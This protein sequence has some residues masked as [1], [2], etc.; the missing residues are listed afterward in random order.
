MATTPE[1]L[2]ESRL[3]ISALQRDQQVLKSSANEEISL[4]QD[5]IRKE[6]KHTSGKDRIVDT[7]RGDIDPVE[8]ERQCEEKDKPERKI[9]LT[10]AEMELKETLD[11]N[12]K[13]VKII[14]ELQQE[15]LDSNKVG[16]HLQQKVTK[17]RAEMDKWRMEQ[18][19]SEEKFKKSKPTESIPEEE[20]QKVKQDF[21]DSK[22]KQN[23]LQSQIAQVKHQK[24]ELVS[25][26][27]KAMEAVTRTPEL[28]GKTL[29]EQA[30]EKEKKNPPSSVVDPLTN[31]TI[32]KL[33]EHIDILEE[34]LKIAQRENSILVEDNR[35]WTEDLMLANQMLLKA[36]KKLMREEKNT[37]LAS[38]T[39]EISA[40][41]K[42]VQNQ[43]VKDDAEVRWKA[44]HEGHAD[45]D[46]LTQEERLE[47][48]IEEY[49]KQIVPSLQKQIALKEEIIEKLSSDCLHEAEEEEELESELKKRQLENTELKTELE[50]TVRIDLKKTLLEDKLM[51][52]INNLKQL[53]LLKDQELAIVKDDIEKTQTN[54]VMKTSPPQKIVIRS[55]RVSRV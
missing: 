21:L 30:E 19:E 51:E 39:A 15:L 16:E 54:I 23:Q 55:A 12:N 40:E 33:D 29:E 9:V 45:H 43:M 17:V 11:Q 36:K 34:E 35:R 25:R 50:K 53:I 37:T 26:L 14:E 46:L 4:L 7:E 3:L 48:L 13:L 31:Q 32:F 52:R 22:T 8:L 5:E 10:P 1:L 2:K 44:A 24:E 38:M 41:K 6:R 47:R 27:R 18:K 42:E 49:E 28:Q 20:I